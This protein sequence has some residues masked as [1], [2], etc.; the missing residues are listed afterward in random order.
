MRRR[1]Q[2]AVDPEL[3]PSATA[4]PVII[5]GMGRIGRAVAD[6]LIQFEISY[7]GLERDQRRLRDAIADG[8]SASFGD[9]ADIRMWETMEL[10]NRKL[11]VLTAP[12]LEVITNNHPV[13]A[14][15]YPNLKRVAAVADEAEAE[16][17]R[18]LG[19]VPVIERGVP[20][21]AH[22]ASL[23]LFELGCDSDKIAAWTRQLAERTTAPAP[24]VIAPVPA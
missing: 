3:I 24:A 13:A 12:K 2:K 21:G 23:V 17:Y 4:A 10:H 14:A 15:Q 9:A 16:K 22:V 5:V 11:S 8:Y 6:A 18:A 19:I 7:V 20:H 1:R